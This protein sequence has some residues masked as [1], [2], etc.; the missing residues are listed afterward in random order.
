MKDFQLTL[1]INEVNQIIKAL[2]HMPFNQVSD[3]IA[4]I[5]AQ[6]QQ[7][8]VSNGHQPSNVEETN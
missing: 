2:G 3:L 6:A 8:L 4:K 5:H 1:N 7:Q